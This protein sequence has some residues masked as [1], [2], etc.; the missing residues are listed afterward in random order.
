MSIFKFTS[1]FLLLLLICVPALAHDDA[2]LSRDPS[3]IL[4]PAAPAAHTAGD[5]IGLI[6]DGSFEYGTCNSGSDWTCDGNYPVFEG[7][8]DPMAVWGYPA[9]DGTL[10]AWLGGF[11]GGQPNINSLCQDIYFEGQ[12]LDWFW[13][14]YVN[15]ACSEMEIRVDGTLVYGH[16]MDMIDHTYGTW[17][18]ASSTIAAPFGVPV[19]M[20]AGGT[21]ELCL[22]WNNDGCESGQN[23]NMLIDFITISHPHELIIHTDGSGD[24]PTIQEGLDA[25]A[26][27]GTVLLGDGVFEGPGNCNIVF[28]VKLVHLR[29]LS[30]SPETCIIRANNSPGARTSSWRRGDPK[31]SYPDR[32]VL[33]FGIML[34]GCCPAGGQITGI[35][36]ENCFGVYGDSG[37]AIYA[38][39]TSPIVS[40]CVFRNCFS[41][42]EGG[43]VELLDSSA[44]FSNCR[45]VN[46][47][48][49]YGGAV[50]VGGE[51]SNPTFSDCLFVG[52]NANQASGAFDIYLAAQA[53][54]QYCVFWNN[55]SEIQ[56]GALSLY[57]S[58]TANIQHCTFAENSSSNG[59]AISAHAPFQLWFNIIAYCTAG[60]AI[61]YQQ[62]GP[63]DLPDIACCNFSG[64][65]GGDWT[66]ELAVLLDT[67]GN[68]SE[69]PQFC[70]MIGTGNFELQSDS[71]CTSGNNDCGTLIG[72]MPQTCGES[73]AKSSS[74]S[75]VKLLY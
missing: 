54:L 5:R 37:G 61:S 62:R 30:S 29:S 58:N 26:D 4:S 68:I 35:T 72:A 6:N 73:S 59:G 7:I 63:G 16:P 71:P 39:G 14:G 42:S 36:F 75:D 44:S 33:N 8:L 49:M 67:D 13:M 3:Q 70:G 40:N 17:N 56:G 11:S 57:D 21:H 10:T 64:N 66:G 41:P 18:T 47:S 19:T 15:D 20:Y 43:A 31:P 23:D 74:W 55:S 22:A 46:N 28:P 60:E 48:S 53:S 45:F 1:T 12:Y 65:T 38:E 2:S 9:Y 51:Y 32:D 52:N 50:C 24:F 25:V 34:S 27:G 69:D